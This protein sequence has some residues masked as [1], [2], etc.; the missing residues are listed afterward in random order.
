MRIKSD[1]LQFPILLGFPTENGKQLAVWCPY[2]VRYHYHGNVEGHRL[3]HC[4]REKSPYNKTG[5]IIKKADNNQMK[6]KNS[7]TRSIDNAIMREEGRS[8]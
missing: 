3:A 4:K 8:L 1:D 6:F 2:C 7:S 5:Y